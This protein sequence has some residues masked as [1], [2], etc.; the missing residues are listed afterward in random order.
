[1]RPKGL[2]LLLSLFIA[3]VG[4]F[5]ISCD[6]GDSSQDNILTIAVRADVTGIYPNPPIQPEAF[7]IDVNSNVF[8]GLVRFGKNMNPEP[9]VAESWENRDDNTWI[10]HLRK[11]IRFSNGDYVHADD[12]VASLQ[13]ALDRPF[14]TSFLQHIQS[15][16]PLSADVVEIKTHYP[17]PILLSQLTVGF[18]MPKKVLKGNNIP[19]IGTGP[20]KVKRWVVGKQL[21]LET[22]PLLPRRASDIQSNPICG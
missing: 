14:S 8:E 13:T 6:L 18:I 3:T 9:A 19:P 10:F 16:R 5:Y 22:E 17:Y 2:V 15:V 11:K 21:D 4:Y 1:M 7:T 12:V 20:Y